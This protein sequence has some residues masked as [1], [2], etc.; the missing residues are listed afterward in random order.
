MLVLIRSMSS[1]LSQMIPS[2][3]TTFLDVLPSLKNDLALEVLSI[4][5]KEPTALREFSRLAQAL[6]ETFTAEELI[7]VLHQ[8]PQGGV[9]RNGCW[10]QLEATRGGD[11]RARVITPGCGG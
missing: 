3:V 9:H 10:T 7:R 11:M 8:A 4:L 6:P 5:I 2:D 1:L